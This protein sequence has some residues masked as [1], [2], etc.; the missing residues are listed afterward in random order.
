MILVDQEMMQGSD[1]LVIT[2]WCVEHI[3]EELNGKCHCSGWKYSI[4]EPDESCQEPE[5]RS[6][7]QLLPMIGPSESTEATSQSI[8]LAS[9]EE[10]MESAQTV[11]VEAK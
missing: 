3:I 4:K 11:K 8:F 2:R 10:N 6:N 1:T 5:S 7:T 9:K